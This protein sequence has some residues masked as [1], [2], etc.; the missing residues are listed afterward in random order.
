M[1]NEIQTSAGRADTHPLA[2]LEAP[3]LWDLYSTWLA[4]RPLSGGIPGREAMDMAV[5]ND[6]LDYTWII[7]ASGKDRFICRR[8]G[9]SAP[10]VPDPPLMDCPL[11]ALFGE[12]IARYATHLCAATL[13]TPAVT[14]IGID[15]GGIRR[16]E[17]LYL[18]LR[19]AEGVPGIVLGAVARRDIGHGP[20]SLNEI[21]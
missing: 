12:D 11:A 1:F 15:R 8:L 19:N 5:L 4:F 7:E 6:G 20:S 14:T 13:R 9:G 18:P 2:G 10:D 16:Y 21:F 3:V 17:H